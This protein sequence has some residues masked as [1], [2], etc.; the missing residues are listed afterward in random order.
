MALNRYEL[1]ERLGELLAAQEGTKPAA[2]K[3]PANTSLDH[4]GVERLDTV[5]HSALVAKHSAP[6]LLLT[7]PEACAELRISR[8]QLYILTNKQHVIEMIHIGKLARI[9]RASL[10]AYV[11]QL[12]EQQPPA[13]RLA[14]DRDLCA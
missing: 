8:A 7:V 1:L 10:E 12:R 3:L 9:P 4:R 14:L 13:T 6:R 11:Q 2:S 5:H